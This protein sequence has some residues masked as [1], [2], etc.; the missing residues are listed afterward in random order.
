MQLGLSRPRRFGKFDPLVG[1]GW[2]TS[3][4]A[5][6]C[7]AVAAFAI[8]TSTIVGTTGHT[9]AQG[10]SQIDWPQIVWNPD[11]ID[12]DVILPL[13]CG[14]AMAFSRIDVPVTDPLADYPFTLGGSD[15]TWS[16][17]E[18]AVEAH[19]S[20]GFSS[21]SG[22]YFLLAKYEVNKLQYAAVMD[23]ECPEAAPPLRLPQTDVSWFDAISFTERA[24]NWLIANAPD[25][26]PVEDGVRGFLRLPTEAEWEFA[27][28]GG[29]AVSDAER[30]ER[31]FPMPEGIEEYA[32]FA[33]SLSS[34]GKAQ[35]IGLNKPNPLG[36]HDIL[37]NVDEIVFEPYRLN[38]G[39]RPHGQAGGYVARGGN[40]RTDR[41][42]LRTSQRNEISFY[43]ADGPNKGDATGFRPSVNVTVLTS[44]QRVEQLREEWGSL[45]APS[46]PLMSATALE[47]P[48]DEVK[49]IAD[50]IDDQNTKNRL[51]ALRDDLR[52][53][54]VARD[55]QR[56][57]AAKSTLRLGAFLCAKLRND[58]GIVDIQR[59]GFDARC[60][61]N[62]PEDRCDR[63]QEQLESNERAL[64][65]VVEYY[66]DTVVRAAQDFSE[67]VLS[68][69]ELVLRAEVEARGVPSV[70][71]WA[72]IYKSQV[73]EFAENG[74]VDR[75]TWL[76]TCKVG[77]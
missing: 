55:E 41:A 29:V 73:L 14:G 10:P 77:N 6:L 18:N 3:V 53:N 24:T 21:H 62:A 25:S 68:D 19:I 23:E 43:G 65:G 48:L 60:P 11:P 72:A 20:G 12:G 30:A 44:L 7:R 34:N 70:A 5:G 61:S 28:R 57:R 49:A 8:A 56:D 66:S 39:K 71:G 46:Q 4:T 76:A 69:Q 45:G 51:I 1:D 52:A 33:G 15:D 35:A 27:A 40:F 67:E 31:L 22:R 74:N 58:A 59:R 9:S 16:F 36:L 26:L 64:S 54:M 2:T 50:A 47:N 42:D 75:P 38:K 37:G 32:W 13:P 63:R 17:S